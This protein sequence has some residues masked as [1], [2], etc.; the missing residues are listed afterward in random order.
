MEALNSTYDHKNY[1]SKWYKFWLENKVFHAKVD[2]SKKPYTILMPPPNV[3]SQLHMGHGTGYSFQDLLIRWKRM[4]GYNA[5]WLPGTDHAGIATQMMVEKSLESE[6]VTRLQLGRE[7]FVEKLEDWQK[8]YG[9]II[10]DQFRHM[11]FSC[12]WDRVAYTMDEHL[13]KAVRHVFVELFNQGLIY[14]GERLVNWDTQ[15]RTAI[16]DDEVENKEV[17]GN[18]WYFKYPV[19]G[20]S[21]W[22]EFAT[23][24][25]ETMLGDTAVAVNPEDDRYRSLIGKSVRLPFTD[26]LV[27]IVA[28]DYV[29]AEFGT[30]VV[31]IT[32]AHDPN[33]FELG[34]RHKLPAINV[35][36]VDGSMNELCPEPFRGKDRFEA[37]KLI[38][39]RMKEMGQFV[40]V[41]P[42][43][44]S[45]PHS[46]RSK[47]I[48][49]PRLSQQ[50]FVR[51]GELAKPAADAAR[52]GT[53]KF[54]PD[55]W[56]KTYLYWL[57]NVQ[58]WCIS[59]Q[60]WWGHRVPIWH[61]QDCSGYS[62]GM[63]DPT[64][65]SKCGSSKLSQDEDVL[66][67]WFSSW[68]WPLSPFGWPDKNLEK[69]MGL[70]YFY[71]TDVLVTATEIIFLWVARMIMVGLR[72]KGK[73]PFTDVYFNA[74]VCDKQGRKFSKTLG[75]GIDPLEVIDKHG[76][77]AVRYTAVSLAPLGGRIKMSIDDFD[78]GARFVNKIW[79]A[80]RF[81][82]KYVDESTELKPLES[83]P[84]TVPQ[85][86]LLHQLHDT[87]EQVEK[88]FSAYRLNDGV[89][90]IYHFIWNAFCDWSIEVAKE[91]L[92]GSD[93]DKKNSTLSV[94]IY[95]LDGLL[96][97][98]HPVM[99]FVTE[100]L[101]QRIP[102]HP[103]WDHPSC[104]AVASYPA[105]ASLRSFPDDAK[106]WGIVMSLI[107][108]FRNLRNQAKFAPK[109]KSN[110]FIQCD[111]EIES[112]LK[113]S[114]GLIER[115]AS[116]KSLKFISAK[117][118]PEDSLVAVGNGYRAFLPVEGNLNLAE[119]KRRLAQ[120]LQRLTKIADG[121]RAKLSSESF[122]GKAPPDVVA[123]T[124]RKLSETDEKCKALQ[125]SLS[126]LEN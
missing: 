87:A 103:D 89:E 81:I 20:T 52:D 28:D 71:P 6:G 94:L 96:R 49:E 11:G 114:S 37:R 12:D 21:E 66:D 115:L 47:T 59:R 88:K 107:S 123:D 34:K 35:M 119:E 74:T 31:K 17:T 56:K 42:Y 58:D 77:D 79:N 122:V 118:R 101:W 78:S 110:G 44:T 91:D 116:H 63:T 50:W 111:P 85:K 23:T 45:L 8:K 124:Q 38:I 46:E 108:D 75:N 53:V 24:R 98:I 112:V 26:R 10:L 109:D 16:S 65:C 72:F 18:L 126:L 73:V 125:E 29:K 62:T 32:P 30:G 69:Q 4:C 106:S 48:I 60:L 19:E 13:S 14:R 113:N 64:K 70:D 67:T 99:P 82:L 76:A 90:D 92:A 41:E 57:D 2:P 80:A 27:P 1:E 39:I 5:C 54:Y 15:L 9:G 121:F 7:K 105:A 83:I 55:A 120:E 117:E 51:M 22:I 86:W 102:R 84:L 100:E 25:P 61:C 93:T 36:N 97:L 33:D 68:L 3:T 95:C 43:K 40:K 104:I